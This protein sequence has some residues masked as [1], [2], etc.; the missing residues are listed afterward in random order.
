[1]GLVALGVMVNLGAVVR[2]IRLVRQLGTGTWVSGKVSAGAV[3]LALVLAAIGVGMAVY[4]V[5]VR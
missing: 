1:V 5:L 4:L 3:A 2:H